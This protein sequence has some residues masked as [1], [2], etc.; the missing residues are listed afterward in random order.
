MFQVEPRG[1]EPL[2]SAVQ[3]PG[4]AFQSVLMCSG[5][6]LFCRCFCAILSLLC[7]AR[8][9]AYR[10]GC[11]TVAVKRLRGVAKHFVLAASYK[12]R[13]RAALCPRQNLP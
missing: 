4:G 9:G 13:L 6:T 10:P 5:I 3:K 1:F 2:T 8:S 12:Y 7:P 11:S